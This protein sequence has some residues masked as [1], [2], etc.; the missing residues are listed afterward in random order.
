MY[1]ALSIFSTWCPSHHVTFGE[2]GIR[3]PVFLLHVTFGLEILVQ[4]GVVI[5]IACPT[6]ILFHVP[7]GSRSRQESFNGSEVLKKHIK[8]C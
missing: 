7:F 1:L 2:K 5:V 8:F 3:V 6:L 4:V